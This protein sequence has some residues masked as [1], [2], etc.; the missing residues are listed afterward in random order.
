MYVIIIVIN[1]F[2]FKKKKLNEK[3]TEK[4]T[5]WNRGI[6][7]RPLA[8]REDRFAAKGRVLTGNVIRCH[9]IKNGDSKYIAVSFSD[10]TCDTIGIAMPVVVTWQG[11]SPN[12]LLE[13]CKAH[14]ID[15]SK[16]SV[17]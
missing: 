5:N 14:G 11:T 8:F 15:I 6:A 9:F 12:Q 2:L 13:T 17:G 3:L 10:L 7:C 4:W 16:K 1:S